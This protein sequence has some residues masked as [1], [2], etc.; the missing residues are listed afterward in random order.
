MLTVNVLNMQNE[1]LDTSVQALIRMGFGKVRLDSIVSGQLPT[2]IPSLVLIANTPQLALSFGYILFNR[3]LTMEVASREWALFAHERKGLRVTTPR[4]EQRSSHWLQL[5]LKYCLP[6]L[7]FSMLIHFTV[8]QSFFLVS[9]DVMAAQ[10]EV[11][12]K[13]YATLGFSGIAQFTT[14]MLTLAIVLCACALGFVRNRHGIP[15]ARSCSA[16]ISAACHLPPWE[17]DAALKKIQWGDVGFVR[18]QSLAAASEGVVENTKAIVRH[19]S[20]SSGNVDLPI[21]GEVYL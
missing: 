17:K 13:N 15:P 20:F 9:I 8:S 1:S 21:E 11:S 14:I 2:T 3:M 18:K 12:I 19:C 16:V 6:L 10:G 7:A 5:P 4:G